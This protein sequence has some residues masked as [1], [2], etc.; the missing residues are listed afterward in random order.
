MN[1]FQQLGF[2]GPKGEPDQAKMKTHILRCMW[3]LLKVQSSHRVG[4]ERESEPYDVVFFGALRSISVVADKI[5]DFD[6]LWTAEALPPAEEQ[7]AMMEHPRSHCEKVTNLVDDSC[8]VAEEG[9]TFFNA[10]CAA[11][12]FSAMVFENATKLADAGWVEFREEVAGF[13]DGG[14]NIMAFLK[15]VDFSAAPLEALFRAVISRCPWLL[16]ANWGGAR[17]SF[18]ASRLEAE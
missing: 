14:L 12:M 16:Y 9:A 4:S 18:V 7:P 1:T 8:D 17:P 10:C 15:K 2:T 13:F 6:L 11:T 5:G 3:D